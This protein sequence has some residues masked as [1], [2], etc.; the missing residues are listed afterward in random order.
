M[1]SWVLLIRFRP[2]REGFPNENK[3][4]LEGNVKNGKHGIAGVSGSGRHPTGNRRQAQCRVGEDLQVAQRQG[5][6]QDKKRG[7]YAGRVRRL[8]Q[9]RE[10][11]AGEVPRVRKESAW[12]RSVTA[13]RAGRSGHEHGRLAHADPP[14][15]PVGSGQ[16]RFHRR[17]RSLVGTAGQAW[18]RNMSSAGWG[19]R[20]TCRRRYGTS[21]F[22]T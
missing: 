3:R 4:L 13:H 9:G 10:R 11:Q 1:P 2:A 18:F 17:G 8:H 5:G 20:N 12:S 14:A 15:M 22:R 6:I 21:Y 19:S 7:R 16:A